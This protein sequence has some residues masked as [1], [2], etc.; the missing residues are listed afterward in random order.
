VP[1]AEAADDTAKP[2]DR[3]ERFL[4]RAGLGGVGMVGGALTVGLVSYMVFPHCTSCE[5]PGL[6]GA[7]L[8]GLTGAVVGTAFFAALPA[9]RDGCRFGDRFV[10]ALLGAGAGAAAGLLGAL[11]TGVPLVVPV[12]AAAG[13]AFATLG[14]RGSADRAEAR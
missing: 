9:M 12:G 14:C 8:G 5:D 7:L 3:N 6:T 1:P 2:P 11:A 13:S 10:R 4:A